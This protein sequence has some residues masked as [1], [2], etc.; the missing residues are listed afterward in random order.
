MIITVLFSAAVL[1]CLRF[2]SINS[3]YPSPD[4]QLYKTGDTLLYN[5]IELQVSDFN[6]VS[7]AEINNKYPAVKFTFVPA[8]VTGGYD[9][10]QIY[11]LLVT[12]NIKNTHDKEVKFP[13]YNMVAETLTWSNGLAAELFYDLNDIGSVVSSIQPTLQPGEE[14]TYILPYVIYDFQLAE[15]DRQNIK[16]LDYNLLFNLYP[17]KIMFALEQ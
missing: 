6:I 1:F 7:W 13:L 12:M 3:S 15:K 17:S 4:S 14:I 5:G 11:A 16:N 10:E 8:S 2:Y 9:A